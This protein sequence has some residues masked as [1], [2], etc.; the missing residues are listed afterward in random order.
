MR[1]SFFVQ[2]NDIQDALRAIRDKITRSRHFQD[3]IRNQEFRDRSIA[4]H[5]FER[6]NFWSMVHMVSMMVAGV[7]QVGEK[8]D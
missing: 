2:V 4:E 7:A 6:V 8:R 1:D 5:N 3:Q